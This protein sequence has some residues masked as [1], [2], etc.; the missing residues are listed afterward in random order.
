[1]TVKRVIYNEFFNKHRLKIIDHLNKKNGW[2]PIFMFG[3]RPDKETNFWINKKF[4]SCVIKN[5]IDMRQAQ[6][7]YSDIGHVRPIDSETIS[8]LSNYALNYISYLQDPTGNNYA[9]EERK[10]Y[11][12]DILKYW[13]T[14]IYNLKPDIFVSYVIPHTPTCLSL[15]LLC[16]HHYNI[17][18]LFV[19]HNPLLDNHSYMISSSIEN[20][21]SISKIY[22][23]KENIIPG[24]DAINYLKSIRKKDAKAPRAIL[25]D[26]K[27][28]E[29]TS[30]ISYRLKQFCLI[31]LKTLIDGY[32]FKID[33]DWKKKIKPYYNKNS[34]MNN[35]EEFFFIEKLRHKNKRLKKIYD[36]YV[37]K[38]DFSEKYIYFAS[39]YQPE[40]SN[41]IVGGYYENF[42]LVLD[43][44]SAAIPN[45]WIIYYKENPTIFSN[46]SLMRGSLRRDKYYYER[47]S[48]YKNI[49]MIS[50]KINT[51]DLID[52]AQAV[53]TITGTVGWEAV[54]RGVPALI[55][56]KIW[57]TGCDSIFS[58]KSFDDAVETMN[59]IINGYKPDQKDIERYTACL[60]K[61]AS[62]NILPIH[63]FDSNIKKQKNSEEALIKIAE[64]I[65]KFYINNRI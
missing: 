28:F 19:D 1:M 43:I 7:D 15:Y 29:K 37:K 60:E 30:K 13:N 10:S 24:T 50:E 25:E 14:V 20:Y 44:L 36:K 57:Y 17:D 16:K 31:I 49:K 12:F 22:K 9:Y 35:F 47:L 62:K 48:R 65:Y 8:S 32:G 4:P 33:G 18:I 41:S 53:S 11:Y 58:I 2:E 42:F 27:L 46:S 52:N 55:F 56:G 64:Y 45:D 51:F 39:Q 5:S 38:V 61:V 23:S 40:A 26:N 21:E 59:K 6:F 54:V 63:N 3:Q 34:R